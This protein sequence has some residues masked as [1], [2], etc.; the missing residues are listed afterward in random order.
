VN[1]IRSRTDFW[2]NGGPSRILLLSTFG[3]VAVA[4]IIPFTGLGHRLGL[5]ALG[6]YPLLVIAGIVA[7]YL[8]AVEFAK[9]YFYGKYGSLIEK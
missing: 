5:V 3:A 8:V 4:W 9:R 6:A 7:A 1:L 2:K